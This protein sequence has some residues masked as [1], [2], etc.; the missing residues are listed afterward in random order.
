MGEQPA[1][2]YMTK[3]HDKREHLLHSGAAPCSNAARGEYAVG[4]SFDMRSVALKAQGAPI[5]I[6]VPIDGVGDDVEGTV[7]V[8]GTRTWRRQNVSPISRSTWRPWRSTASSTRCSPC[9]A[10]RR[11]SRTTWPSFEGR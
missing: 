2:D 3:L 11:A 9:L 6:I 10:C 1:W 7:I 5:D 4:I 8:K